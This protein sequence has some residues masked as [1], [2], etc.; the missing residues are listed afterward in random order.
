MYQLCL[1]EH[2]QTISHI[3]QVKL[4]ANLADG[5]M[6]PLPLTYAIHSQWGNVLPQLLFNDSSRAVEV[7]A[8]W[9]GGT[10]QSIYLGF[11]AL[12]PWLHAVSYT[13]V[14]QGHNMIAKV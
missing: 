4:C 12:P 8:D 14:I 5:T 10:S 13:F 11:L 2:P 1:T 3:N 7:G 6:V 9:N